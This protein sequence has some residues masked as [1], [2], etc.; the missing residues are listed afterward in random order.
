LKDFLITFNENSGEYEPYQG[1]THTATFPDTVYGGVWKPIEGKAVIEWV[2]VDMGSV[3]YTSSDAGL[4]RYRPSNG[5]ISGDVGSN[6]NDFMCSIYAN[7]SD[8]VIGS[9]NLQNLKCAKTSSAAY[10]SYYFRDDNYSTIEAF[11]T[12]MSGQTFCY[13]LATPIEITLTAEQI[14]LLKGQNV[15]WTD[16][17]NI[18]LTYNCDIKQW[19]LNQLQS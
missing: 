7:Q 11:K 9:Q 18:T 3:E 1:E 17:D 19:V 8:K 14:E 15:L 16:G 12:A 10:S 6:A 13:K 5:I 4:F 2:S